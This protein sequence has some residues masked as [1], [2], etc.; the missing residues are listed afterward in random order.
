MNCSDCEQLS[1]TDCGRKKEGY[2]FCKIKESWV[3]INSK[4]WTNPLC[5]HEL[6]KK[7]PEKINQVYLNWHNFLMKNR[8]DYDYDVIMKDFDKDNTNCS[9]CSDRENVSCNCSS[10]LWMARLQQLIR[11]PLR[12]EK[13]AESV[14]I[15]QL[16][17]DG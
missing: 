3:T 6:F 13:F 17:L 7:H 5:N 11:H 4:C 14:L 8:I 16:I 1:Y 9:F 15:D 2:G 10:K 12:Y